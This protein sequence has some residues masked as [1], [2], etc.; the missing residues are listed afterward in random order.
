MAVSLIVAVIT[1]LVLPSTLL[2][3]ATLVLPLSVTASSPRP[4]IVPAVPA[5][6]TVI[7]SAANPVS[8]VTEAA[9]RATAE[10]LTIVLRSTASAVVPLVLI[11]L[12]TDNTDPDAAARFDAV[13]LM[14]ERL[15]VAAM[16]PSRLLA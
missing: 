6:K 15:S 5:P 3:S 8:V 2:A 1:P 9:L 11:A 14:L 4:M 7:T 12:A 16:V 10:V 13:S